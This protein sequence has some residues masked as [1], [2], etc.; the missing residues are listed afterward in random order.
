MIDLPVYQKDITS[1]ILADMWD[2]TRV[3]MDNDQDM[4]TKVLI[5][6]WNYTRRLATC[7]QYVN[8]MAIDEEVEQ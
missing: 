2:A 3:A 1:S 5:N 8:V 4:R 6:T 7:T